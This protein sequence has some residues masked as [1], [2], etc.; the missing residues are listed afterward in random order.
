VGLDL[1]EEGLSG[2]D[3]LVN[4]RGTP[5]HRVVELV[6]RGGS[7][8]RGSKELR[9]R[10][11]GSIEALQEVMSC[12]LQIPDFGLEQVIEYHLL[13]GDGEDG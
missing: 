5:I 8:R 7:V 4:F 2:L 12:Y 1:E 3:N 9:A 10:G 6:R 13:P 11:A